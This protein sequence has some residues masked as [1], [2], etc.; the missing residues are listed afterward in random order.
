MILVILPLGGIFKTRTRR[1][2]MKRWW[3]AGLILLL[4]SPAMGAENTD[5]WVSPRPNTSITPDMSPSAQ[6]FRNFMEKGIWTVITAAASPFRLIEATRGAIS[7]QV[8]KAKMDKTGTGAA[9]AYGAEK[10]V[11]N[12]VPQVV[13][14]V[15]QQI[16]SVAMNLGSALTG[17][18][19]YYLNPPV[20]RP[21]FLAR[22]NWDNPAII[23]HVQFVA[24]VV[25]CVAPTT[26]YLLGGTAGLMKGAAANIP[27]VVCSI[28]PGTWLFTNGV[29][30]AVRADGK[31]EFFKTE[32][33]L[34]N[35]AYDKRKAEGPEVPAYKAYLAYMYGKTE[36]RQSIANSF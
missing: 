4:C 7:T 1:K 26:G 35:A 32:Y 13:G 36:I 5:T 14:D 29:M 2:D 12:V 15:G 31:T 11:N 23:Q 25:A 8:R 33:D 19:N 24:N 28:G 3:I 34:V 6:G 22:K 10:A 9:T 20:D 17:D 18:R 16:I 30:F 27:T 21:N